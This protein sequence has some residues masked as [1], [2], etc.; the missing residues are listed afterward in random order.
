MESNG[1][2]SV[3]KENNENVDLTVNKK[4]AKQNINTSI[5]NLI[6]QKELNVFQ[7]AE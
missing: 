7:T 4:T 1:S 5:S 6:I 3:N 2:F